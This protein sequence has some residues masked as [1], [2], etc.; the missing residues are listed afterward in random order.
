[1]KKTI[2]AFYPQME[3]VIEFYMKS[4]PLYSG[5]EVIPWEKFQQSGLSKEKVIILGRHGNFHQFD[6]SHIKVLREKEVIPK[7]ENTTV[8]LFDWHEDLDNAPKGTELTSASWAYLGLEE[9]LYSNLYIIGTDPRG[10]DELNPWQYEEEIRPP[11]GEILRKMNRI[12]LFPAASSF[13]R[14]KFFSECEHFISNNESVAEY[15]VVKEGGF[16]EV[17]FRSMKEVDYENRKEA[18]VVSIDLDVLKRSTLRTIC[19]QGIMEDNELISHLRKVRESGP[20]NAIL[21]CGLT[22]EKGSQDE[23]SL[24]SLSEILS[25]ANALL[26]R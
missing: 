1:M 19:P 17:R 20:I 11:K 7:P 16:V 25:E 3:K 2:L 21:I 24:Y 9:N 10:I 12:F 5:E 8:I 22:E 15:F 23:W 4:S 18:V 14:L 26:R 13:S 6:F